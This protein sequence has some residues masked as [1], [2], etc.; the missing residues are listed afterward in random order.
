FNFDESK[1]A[2]TYVSWQDLGLPAGVPVHVFDF[3]N[4]EYLGACERGITVDLQPTSCRV[5]TLLP[6]TDHAQ[7]ISTSR[8]ITQGWVD[9]IA[10]NYN[11]ATNSYAGR[12][13]VIKNDP[14]ELRFVFPRGKNLTIKR[15]TARGAF[16]QMPVKISNHQ[17]WATV[18]FTAPQT[19]KVSWAVSFA[20][21]DLYRFPVREPQ[22]VW[23]ERSGLDGINLRW[24]VQHQPAAGYLVSLNGEPRGF[25]PTQVF[26]LKGLSADASYTA[27]VQ[28]VWQDGTASEKKAQ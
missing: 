4:K 21:A 8:H 17:G 3:W 23:A 6:A 18:A 13:K 26:A 24:N 20:P 27:E 9:L 15:A 5:L 28:T 12:S 14:Y 19:A 2:P 22:N 11:P 25:T 16:G 7:L 10:Q 1:R